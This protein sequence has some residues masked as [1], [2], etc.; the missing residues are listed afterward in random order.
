VD[1]FAARKFAQSPVAN[2][3]TPKVEETKE[4]RGLFRGKKANKLETKQQTPVENESVPQPAPS[5]VALYEKVKKCLQ[6]F[7]DATLDAFLKHNGIWYSKLIQET[8]N[9]S[10]Q[11]LIKFANEYTYEKFDY[12]MA[13]NYRKMLVF[14]S[15]NAD[16]LNIDD[17]NYYDEIKDILKDKE[18]QDLKECEYNLLKNIFKV[19][20]DKTDTK[21]R[22]EF[23]RLYAFVRASNSVA[24][25]KET[26]KK[27]AEVISLLFPAII[28]SPKVVSDFIPCERGL[29]NVILFDEASQITLEKGV[30]IIYRGDKF[31]IVG[32]SNQ[33]PPESY[34]ESL[35][36]RKQLQE[37]IAMDDTKDIEE[38]AIESAASLL[39]YAQ[40]KVP[41]LTLNYHYR[42]K[43]AD[44]IAFNNVAFYSNKL[45]VAN[46]PK[47]PS[48]G[49]KVI[50]VQGT[51]QNL[52]NE[53]E[54]RKAVEVV[55]SIVK[56]KKHGTI[57]IIT[58]SKEMRD[59]VADLIINHK[60]KA[61]G[62]EMYRYKMNG[63]FEG[64][65]IKHVNTV[66]GEERD[67]IIV[68]CGFSND[69][70]TDRLFEDSIGILNTE[71]GRNYIN[72]M[73]SR[74][75]QNLTIIKSFKTIDLDV[76]ELNENSKCFVDYLKYAEL[77]SVSHDLQNDEDIKALFIP[78]MRENGEF[79]L[80]ID[81]DES[82]VSG[83]I[84]QDS[85]LDWLTKEVT[86]TFNELID[87]NQFMIVNNKQE[88]LVKINICF[89]NKKDGS[90]PLGLICNR[91]VNNI[92]LAN[93][94]RDFY[95]KKFL[96][97]KD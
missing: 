73:F 5:V 90:I 93:K 54:A 39:D 76:N 17:E 94:E 70:K 77:F 42:S 61:I 36:Q 29:F 30:P 97:N 67:N 96:I 46:N 7:D 45:N 68:C 86:E 23:N 66:Q 26:F 25:V 92:N 74:A 53:A 78:Y 95:A 50:D 60:N 84:D 72:V 22:D 20:D 16:V 69:V 44:L 34:F 12:A 75:K 52:I 63:E 38:L 56:Q 2:I 3:E 41:L 83:E 62:N 24:S 32:D 89:T 51:Y 10:Y 21:V 91:F 40:R 8:T 31:C 81:V 33:L 11:N 87:T 6:S 43:T 64:L 88:G 9:S 13:K 4:K 37:K 85:K 47:R 14:A 15:D 1:D 79:D 55:E 65:F 18:E 49:L 59:Y 48:T 19:L 71:I 28:C 57:G 82:E 27:Y 58:F 80:N 35:K